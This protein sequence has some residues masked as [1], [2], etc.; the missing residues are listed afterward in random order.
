VRSGRITRETAFAH[1][2][3]TDDLQRYLA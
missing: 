3:R 2:Y 1:G